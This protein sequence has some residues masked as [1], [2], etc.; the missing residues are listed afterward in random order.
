MYDNSQPSFG[1]RLLRALRNMLI[2]GVLLAAAGAA[3]ASLSMLNARTFSLEVRDGKLVVLKGRLMPM[4]FEPWQ[5]TDPG[6][7]DAYAP[8]DLQGNTALAVVGQRFADRDEL[9]RAFFGVIELL[10][11]PRTQSESPKDLELGSAYVRRAEH[12]TGLTDEQKATLKH[13]HADVAFYLA[14]NGLDDARK[15]LDEALAQLKLASD[16]D[17]KHAREANQMLLAV[18]PQVKTLSDA[19][20][21]AVHSLSAPPPAPAPVVPS[22]AAVVPAPAPK[23]E[24]DTQVAP[25]PA[26][27]QLESGAPQTR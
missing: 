16:V 9:D 14:R 2:F 21:A 3:L 13:L 7:A 20:R 5:P 27:T 11:R 12:L 19:L 17:A 10:A 26:G 24:P 15:Q 25:P 18:E 1:A 23:Q 8:L 22:P 6:Q 4:G